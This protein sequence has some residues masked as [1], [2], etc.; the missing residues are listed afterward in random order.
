MTLKVQVIK[1]VSRE[2]SEELQSY[3]KHAKICVDFFSLA[4]FSLCIC[5]LF[6][7]IAIGSVVTTS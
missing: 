5:E 4:V 7:D 1:R 2:L 6:P 3:I